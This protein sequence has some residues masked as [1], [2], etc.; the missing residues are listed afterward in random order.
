[1]ARGLM[2]AFVQQLALRSLIAGG[3]WFAAA[4][5]LLL[6]GSTRPVRRP[7]RS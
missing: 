1:L 6:W 4:I 3:V 7:S 2:R 5:V